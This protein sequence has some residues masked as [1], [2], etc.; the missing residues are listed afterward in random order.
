MWVTGRTSQI[1]MKVRRCNLTVLGISEI[2]CIQAEQ[3][4]TDSG[5]MLLYS[6]HEEENASHIQEVALNLSKEAYNA[7]MRWESHRCR[8]I[9]VSFKTK[10]EGNTMNIIQCYASTNDSNKDDKD[11]FYE[12]LQSTITIVLEKLNAKVGMENTGYEDIMGR[13]ELEERDENNERFANLC[14]F[15]KMI[16]GGTIFSHKRIHK[17]T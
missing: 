7:L 10:K 5:E 11:Q 15:N 2:L 13:N 14:P 16:I 1:V 6:G 17:A 8:I 3:K 4:R 9:K 12:W